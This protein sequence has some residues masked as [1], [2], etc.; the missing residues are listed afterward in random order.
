M[1][2]L[3]RKLTTKS[4]YSVVKE[5]VLMRLTPVPRVPAAHGGLGGAKLGFRIRLQQHSYSVLLAFYFKVFYA[6]GVHSYTVLSHHQ[7]VLKK[8]FQAYPDDQ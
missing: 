2:F 3:N 5:R 4:F 7:K 1:V 8:K 6:S